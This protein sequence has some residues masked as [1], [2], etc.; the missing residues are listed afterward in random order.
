M[1]QRTL[2]HKTDR[3]RPSGRLRLMASDKGLCAPCC[4]A[5][6]AAIRS[7][8]P[9]SLSG[10][11]NHPVLKKAEKQLKE[12]FAGKRQQFDLPLDPHGTVRYSRWSAWK[13]A[14]ENSLWPDHLLWRAGEAPRRRQESTRRRHGE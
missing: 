3:L 9:A 7:R 6:A 2:Y 8:Y 5:V 11:R 12:Y 1:L 14:A 10:A 4:F 13:R